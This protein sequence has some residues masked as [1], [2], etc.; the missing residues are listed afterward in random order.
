MHELVSDRPRI[1][2]RTSALFSP[3]SCDVLFG[4]ALNSS[5]MTNFTLATSS[6]LPILYVPCHLYGLPRD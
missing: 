6:H 2:S 1:V 3:E 4:S 5:Q